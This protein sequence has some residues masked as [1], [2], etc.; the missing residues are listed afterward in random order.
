M[1]KAGAMSSGFFMHVSFLAYLIFFHTNTKVLFESGKN[2]NNFQAK[3]CFTSK[4]IE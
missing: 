4:S 2:N 3:Q 1:M